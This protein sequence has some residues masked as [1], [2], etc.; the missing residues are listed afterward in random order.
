MSSINQKIIVLAVLAVLAG[1]DKSPV[2]FGASAEKSSATTTEQSVD[3]GKEKKIETDS[4]QAI[5]I[6]MS[7]A[8]LLADAADRFCDEAGIK[9]SRKS[10]FFSSSD[11]SLSKKSP[12]SIPDQYKA[13][14]AALL[15]IAAAFEPVQG[16]P[17]GGDDNVFMIRHAALAN[18]VNAISNEAIAKLGDSAL[19]D[20]AAAQQ[21][22]VSAVA[23]I[24]AEVLEQQWLDALQKAKAAGVPSADLTGSQAPIEYKIGRQVVKMGSEGITL[25]ASGQVQFGNGKIAGKE[26]DLSLE[27]SLTSGL[28]KKL[29]LDTKETSTETE[30]AKVDAGIKN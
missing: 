19:K 29:A 30:T 4:K 2:S 28:S 26:I 5:T 18:F 13:A 17:D 3:V 23:A 9:P 22:I 6:K 14:A 21:Q 12:K 16:W 15:A 1:C 8:T 7:A 11:A 25:V 27:T 10:K 20:P 24:P